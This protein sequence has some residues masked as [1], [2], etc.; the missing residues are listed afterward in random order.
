MISRATFGPWLALILL[1]ITVPKSSSQFS[2]PL[3]PRGLPAVGY[4]INAPE[5][6]GEVIEATTDSDI[7]VQ[8]DKIPH[9][10]G[11]ATME[12]PDATG[13]SSDQAES[14]DGRSTESVVTASNTQAEGS[15]T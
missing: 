3:Q 14:G 11:Y 10:V 15:S 2:P 13:E 1:V 9:V 5:K 12:E 6:E 7:K 8:R 4:A